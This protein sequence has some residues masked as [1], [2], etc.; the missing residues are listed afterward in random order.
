MATG[1]PAIPTPNR[2]DL[3]AIQAAIQGAR[4]RI[5]ALEAQLGIVSSTAQQTSST[6][7]SNLNSILTQ[8]SNLTKRVIALEQAAT[9]DI[10]QF[11]AGESLVIGQ[12]VVPITS[13][14]IGAVDPSD[15][16]RIFGLI[17]IALNSATPG[18]AVQV[19]RR[20]VLTLPGVSGLIAGRAVYVDGVGVTQTPDYDAT[21]I[22]IGVAV[23]TTQI[24]I[25]PDW[26]A[27]LYPTF[28][29]GFV[30]HYLDYLP[31][32]FRALKDGSS[33]EAMIDNLPFNSG[34]DSHAQVPMTVNGVAVRVNAGD[35]GGG[36]GLTGITALTGDVAASGVGSVATTLATVNG[37]V[38]SFTS[39]NIT[40]NGKGLITAA[41]AGA[42]GLPDFTDTLLTAIPNVSVNFAR[43]QASGGATDIAVG[44]QWKGSGY[45]AVD[46]P[47]GATTGGNARGAFAWDGQTG[48]GGLRSAA[49]HIASGIRSA[50]IATSDAKADGVQSAVIASDRGQA[51]GDDSLVTGQRGVT[52]GAASFAMG[53]FSS[54]WGFPAVFVIGSFGNNALGE[55]QTMVL[56]LRATIAFSASIKILTVGG[57]VPAFPSAGRVAAFVAHVYMTVTG[58]DHLYGTLEGMLAADYS[59]AGIVFVGGIAPTPTYKARTAGAIANWSISASL[60]TSVGGLNVECTDSSGGGIVSCRCVLYWMTN[61][62]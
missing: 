46:T 29:S 11:V 62:P 2:I 12:G 38:G 3:R 48:S 13:T 57:L 16:T 59:L 19:Q 26:P 14:T 5:E 54:D 39:A 7:T 32:T 58:G 41:A 56:Q 9:T 60:D 8:L 44:F 17:G 33:L 61:Q 45:F 34:V 10:G 49:N 35:I 6:S 18:T 37:N 51:L 1:F 4:Q 43:L 28:S 23:S 36:G 42:G 25:S 22:P 53:N 24:F 20:G 31:V 55:S 27:L 50:L 52:T 47:D 40:V 30:D 21:A 15:P